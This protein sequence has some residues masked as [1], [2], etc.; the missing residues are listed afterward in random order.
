MSIDIPPPSD[1]E[2]LHSYLGKQLEG[3]NELPSLDD[4]LAGFQT[5]YRQLHELRV[6]VHQAEA[7]LNQGKG[8][9]LDV[10]AVIERVRKRL[11]EK[12]I[13]E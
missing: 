9:P 13:V 4:A 3:S 2:L 6:K 5:Y 1:V 11:A 12:G 10:D 8:A 7:S